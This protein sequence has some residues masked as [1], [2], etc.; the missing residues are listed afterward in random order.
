MSAADGR[1]EQLESRLA[2]IEAQNRLLEKQRVETE[3]ELVK[4]KHGKE[5]A[6]FYT[7]SFAFGLMGTLLGLEKEVRAL[8]HELAA[9]T[10]A[11]ADLQ[12]G[13]EATEAR[14]DAT[15]GKL[16]LERQAREVW[17]RNHPI[18]LSNELAWS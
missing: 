5:R 7:D 1:L 18:F 6:T 9:C 16:R 2:E 14:E 4:E 17:F 12:K 15:E 10:K 8:K 11:N 13:R 3:K